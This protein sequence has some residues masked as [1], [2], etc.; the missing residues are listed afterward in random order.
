MGTVVSTAST[1]SR[2]SAIQTFE[3]SW[4]GLNLLAVVIRDFST[5]RE[6]SKNPVGIQ[7]SLSL[8]LEMYS[9]IPRYYVQ[10]RKRKK[11]REERKEL[12][13]LE[14]THPL[15]VSIAY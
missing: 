8:S 14:N 9:Y 5:R 1:S 15:I 6:E 2:N 4:H 12:E 10:K 13:Y 11:K 3:T 7:S